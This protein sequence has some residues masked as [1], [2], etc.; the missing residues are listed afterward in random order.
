[1]DEGGGLLNRYAVNSR[2]G[3]SNPPPSAIVLVGQETH[4]NKGFPGLPFSVYHTRLPHIMCFG[5]GVYD[6]CVSPIE[7]PGSVLALLA[8]IPQMIALL[9]ATQS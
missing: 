9:S 4:R 8:H 6:M 3:G 1:M 2:I 5:G 7:N